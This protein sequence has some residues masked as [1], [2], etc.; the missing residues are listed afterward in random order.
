MHSHLAVSCVCPQASFVPH[1]ICLLPFSSSASTKTLRRA[2]L[3]SQL[4]GAFMPG[5]D[6]NISVFQHS[7]QTALVKYVDT[8]GSSRYSA[9]SVERYVEGILN[10]SFENEMDWD[11]DD[12]MPKQ[13]R[14]PKNKRNLPNNTPKSGSVSMHRRLPN[15]VP[16]DSTLREIVDLFMKAKS[17][18]NE[19][20]AGQTEKLLQKSE[21]TPKVAADSAGQTEKLLQQPEPTPKLAADSAS[22]TERLLQ[23]SEP[24]HRVAADS[25]LQVLQKFSNQVPAYSKKQGKSNKKFQGQKGMTSS[26]HEGLI[27]DSPSLATEEETEAYEYKLPNAATR[28]QTDVEKSSVVSMKHL[29]EH[30]DEPESDYQSSGEASMTATDGNPTDKDEF[31]SSVLEQSDFNTMKLSEMKAIAKSRGL[32]GYSKLNKP[33]LLDLLIK[34]TC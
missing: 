2:Y 4:H 14:S 32:K 9:K 19:A 27:M 17:K 25:V 29:N 18:P 31:S 13:Y 10:D 8:N 26:Q 24:T 1:G 12:S 28:S 6:K 20:V 16:S 23:K 7:F 15:L 3:K 33:Q 11:D 21:P 5:K 30:E 22:Q 34:S